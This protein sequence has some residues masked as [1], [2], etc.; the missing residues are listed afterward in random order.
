MVVDGRVVWVDPATI[1]G[2]V[3]SAEISV[4]KVLDKE[5]YDSLEVKSPTTLYCVRG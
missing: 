4:I 1:S 5:E 3:S 2:L